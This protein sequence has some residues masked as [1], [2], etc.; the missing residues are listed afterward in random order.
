MTKSDEHHR[1]RGNTGATYVQNKDAEL[2][3]GL[4]SP[5]ALAGELD[6]LLEL[7]DGVLEGS[8]GIVDLIDDE[9][10][11][12]DQVLH[13]AQGAEIKPLSAGNLSTQSLHL[14]VVAQGLVERQTD[15]LDGDVGRAGLLEEGSKDTSGNIA[16]TADGDHQ[17]R[18]E[19]GKQLLSRLLAQLVHLF[20]QPRVSY[21]ETCAEVAGW[22]V[23]AR[24]H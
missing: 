14:A 6:V 21:G 13:L 16:T 22:R 18:L 4:V 10:A 19:V 3:L 5:Q 7:L 1:M 11:L 12:A 23:A 9:D 2:G 17:M 20:E 24:L 15:G 8:A